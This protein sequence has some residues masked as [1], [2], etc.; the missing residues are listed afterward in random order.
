[1]RVTADIVFRKGEAKQQVAFGVVYM[2]NVVDTH[3]DFMRADEIRKAA[4]DLMRRGTTDAIDTRHNNQKSGAYIVE[5]FLS[6][7]GDPDFPIEGSWVVG[8][9]VP[10]PELW[11]EI[12]K[13]ELG[14][15]SMEVVAKRKAGVDVDATLTPLYA[16]GTAIG[17]TQE[18]SNHEHTYEVAYGED[19][20]FL[21]GRTNTV[22]GHFHIIKSGAI[23][24]LTEETLGHSHRFSTIEHF[25]YAKGNN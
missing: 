13:G 17:K 8:I 22:D 9:H 10:D 19:G 20:G 6:R 11:A 2:P 24:V 5:S 4:Y 12:E 3:G 14:G 16:N 1:M 7:K 23:G 25:E 15:L 18:A 21:G